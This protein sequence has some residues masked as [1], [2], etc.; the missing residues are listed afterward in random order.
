MRFLFLRYWFKTVYFIKNASWSSTRST[1][2]KAKKVRLCCIFNN[3]HW[4]KCD[5]LIRAETFNKAAMHI[6]YTSIDQLVE[7]FVR[8][9][10]QPPQCDQTWLFALALRLAF[11][12][13]KLPLHGLKKKFHYSW[14]P[15]LNRIFS[16]ARHSTK[17][18][19]E[20]KLGKHF[21]LY[22]SALSKS[23][24]TVL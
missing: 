18:Q 12:S 15:R 23:I 1:T 4:T 22:L 21:L 14:T 17:S 8:D 11:E 9:C 13:I 3:M 19:L 16:F 20:G 5:H 6:L 2:S 10:N 24:L 7:L